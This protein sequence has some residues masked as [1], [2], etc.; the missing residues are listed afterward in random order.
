[1][2]CEHEDKNVQNIKVKNSISLPPDQESL[3]HH[4]PRVHHL[5]TILDALQRSLVEELDF[6]QYGWQV[7]RESG[8]FTPVWF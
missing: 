5:S 3:K 8:I 4:L 7:D 2:Y 6:E 1:M